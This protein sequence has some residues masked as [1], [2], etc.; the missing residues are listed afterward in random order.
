[1]CLFF[2]PGGVLRPRC[3][4]DASPKRI[5]KRPGRLPTESFYF[6]VGETVSEVV[7]RTVHV[8]VHHFIVQLFAERLGDKLGNFQITAFFARNVE[9][10]AM[11]AAFGSTY[12]EES[13]QNGRRAA[14]FARFPLFQLKS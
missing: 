1:M 4:F 7:P 10:C 5:L 13:E 3:P 8:N 6:L 9:G 11:R 2:Q 12:K 14:R